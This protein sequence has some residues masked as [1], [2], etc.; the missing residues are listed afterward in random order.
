MDMMKVAALSLTGAVALLLFKQYKPEWG[1]PLR[2]VLGIALGGV[3]L[4]GV[5]EILSFSAQLAA[6]SPMTE[7]MWQIILKAMGIAFVTETAAG[8][9]TDSGESTLAMW[10]EAAGKTALVLLALPLI[11]E[12]LAGVGE[13]LSLS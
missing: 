11:K 2:L 1:I 6:E 13:L 8:I 9:C 3:I 7:R 10:V 5:E 12:M 4:A